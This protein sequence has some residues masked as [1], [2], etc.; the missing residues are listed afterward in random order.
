MALIVF[1]TID[2]LADAAAEMIAAGLQEA[3]AARGIAHLALSGGGTPRPVYER[4][5]VPPFRSEI[6]W[7][8]VH[9]WWADER[10]VP[11]DDEG[12]NYRLARETFLAQ[13]P[14]P[15]ANIHRVLG[16]LPLS[17]AAADYG[18]Q[19]QAAALP[20]QL[21][22]RLDIAILGMGADGHTA[23]L[24][25][26]KIS[27][28]ELAGSV[29]PVTAEYDGRPAER[30]SL[31]LPVLNAARHIVFLV[32]GEEKGVTLAAVQQ[33]PPQLE[34]YPAQRIRPID[35]LVTWLAD[36]TAAEKI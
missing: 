7:P 27:D 35:G 9:I 12:S 24:F 17:A 6:P 25:P 2:E 22:P 14:V 20:G 33:Q 11:P 30:V 3:A 8:A 4:L 15:S 34:R 10:C 36:R 13:V 18:Q 5:A 21:W 32:T 19:L 28:G 23:S 26:G 1:Q 16:E 29:L 31:T